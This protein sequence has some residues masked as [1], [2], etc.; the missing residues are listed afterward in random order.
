MFVV[1]WF[2]AGAV[3]VALA[4]VGVSM[5]GNQVTG[6]R[7]SPLSA[8]EVRRELVGDDATT[9]TTLPDDGTTSVPPGSAT[10]TTPSA[11]RTTTPTSRPSGSAGP[12]T[13]APTTLP[14]APPE[15]RTYVLV[16]GTA[17]L[18]FASS[19]VTVTDATPNAGYSV[20]IEP[21][22][23]NGFSVDFRSED[24]RSRVK[25]WWDGGPRDEVEERAE[26]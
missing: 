21:E 15:T 23:T 6:S 9:T 24:H 10:T 25:G 19:G 12:A 8:E 18:Q 7:P 26:G 16:G 20:S 2:A 22:H 4:T 11:P 17:T 3:S 5:V 13:T 14:E 1:A